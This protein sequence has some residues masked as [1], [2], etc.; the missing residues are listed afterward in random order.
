MRA[1]RERLETLRLDGLSVAFGGVQAV[2]GVSVEI[3]GGEIFGLI[4][5]NGAGKTTLLNLVSRLI[6]AD[7]GSIYWNEVALPRRS[8][9]LAELG[10]ARTF[11]TPKIV[12]ECS[13]LENVM[14]GGHR[15][16]KSGMLR[17]AVGTPRARSEERG[18]RLQARDALARCGYEGAGSAVGRS[19]SFAER[20]KVELARCLMADPALILLDEPTSGLDRVEVDHLLRTI[21]ELNGLGTTF[22]LVEHN[23]PLV[24]ELCRTIGVMVLGELLTSGTS[25][26]VVRD[27]RVV[28][29][30]LVGG[31]ASRE[32]VLPDANR[33]PIATPAAVMGKTERAFSV[34]PSRASR[35]EAGT[36][37]TQPSVEKA[38]LV[39]RDLHAGYGQL[40]VLRGMSLTAHVGHVVLVMGRNGVGKSTFFNALA[41][42]VRCRGGHITWRGARLEQRSPRMRMKQGVGLVPQGGGVI[43][44]QSVRENLQLSLLGASC[45]RSEV[46]TRIEE[47]FGLF[48]SLADRQGE[49]GRNLSGG[50]RQMLAIAKVLVKKPALLLLDEPS[51]GLA[52]RVLDDLSRLI[53]SLRAAGMAI[54]IA[55]QN[56]P[57]CRDL[58]DHALHLEGGRVSEVVSHE[59]LQ[60]EARVALLY[61]GDRVASS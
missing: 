30:Y 34:S 2:K 14:L 52:P 60:D 48:P 19:L 5:P 18:L 49:H 53:D 44:G 17:A 37:P 47:V 58:V 25:D 15:G 40:E 21:R 8:R 59:D 7:S 24:A 41:G 27:P 26:A 13:V 56:I 10:L 33:G 20:R 12:D 61:L 16:V 11:Q 35:S 32:K 51:I 46:K 55:E 36:Q 6:R 42:L 22:V 38:D 31:N 45:G 43:G 50:E 39:V 29:A 28:A 57:W 23:V 9:R 1:A 54:C 4:G 3:P